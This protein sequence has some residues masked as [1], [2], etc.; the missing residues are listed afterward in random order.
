MPVAL[1]ALGFALL[2]LM[3]ASGLYGGGAATSVGVSVS[4]VPGDLVASPQTQI[5]FRGLPISRLGKIV[6][7]GSRSGTH[8]GLLMADS[9]GR[10]GSFLPSKPFVP[11]EEV[12]VRTSLRVSDAHDGTWR[13]RVAEPAGPIP[14]APLLPAARV[15]GDVLTFQS[16]PN[17][18]PPAVEITDS[19]STAASGDIFLTPQYGPVQSGPMIVGPEGDLV[20]FHP[21]ASGDIAA[22]FRVQSYLGKPV[23]T[24]WQGY[25][26]AGVG[27]GED[28]IDNSSY[29]QIGV[30]RAGNGLGADLHEFELTPEGTALITAY[31]PV[32]WNASSVGGSTRQ[33]VL[34]SVVQEI[35]VKT[36][37]VMFQWDS[38]NHV[39]LADSYE[40]VPKSAGA[41]F[42]YFH[43]NSVQ[44]VSGGELLISG[45]NTW[46]AYA[47][48]TNGGRTIWTLGGKHS[49]FRIGAGA[50]FALQHDV[51]ISPDG[52]TVTV[53]D[54]G[55]GP[56][57]VQQQSRGLTLRLDFKR[58]TA[59]LIGEDEHSP[60]LL[61]DFEGD[62]Q[63]LGNGDQFLGW[64]QQ[65]YF[66]EFDSRGQ[67]IFDG[68]FVGDN[69]SYRA[70]RYQWT[71]TPADPP[72]IAASTSDQVTSVF[73]SWNGATNVAAWQVMAGNRSDDLSAVKTAATQG[74][75]TEIQI[76]A[77][78]YVAVR[79]LDHRGHVLGTSAVIRP[80]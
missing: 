55:A 7:T 11:G 14:D 60:S 76:P 77:H 74:F 40:P 17:L 44:Q 28:V 43:V 58:K 18:V 65:P 13:F 66:S 46:A 50:T 6:V 27:V 73:A 61:A 29:Q 38:L 52:R 19:S 78:S 71:G 48:S 30:V 32:Y 75:E 22:D 25:T 59:T 72:S 4:P 35:D 21:V 67:M 23:L 79:P 31:Y 41:P 15:P 8:T 3:N 63:T 16:E 26:G 69:S 54:D 5:S 80:G 45:R 10:G 62:V 33:V 47:V 20:W 36:G 2:V 12:T 57:V 49:T 42:D 51:R 24:W 1:I 37:L 53:F 70:Y 34:D 39:P 64:G 68:R 9:D 56:P